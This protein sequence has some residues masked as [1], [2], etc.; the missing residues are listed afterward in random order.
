MGNIRFSTWLA[1]CAAVVLSIYC[2]PGA[3]MASSKQ[4]GTATIVGWN[5]THEFIRRFFVGDAWGSNVYP[6]LPSGSVCCV[7]YPLKWTADFKVKVRWATASADP[8]AVGKDAEP[9]WHEQEVQVEKYDR[10]GTL[11][12]HFLADRK[13][14]VIIAPVDPGHP[15]YPGPGRPTRPAA[16]PVQKP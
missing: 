16:A 11:H 3:A 14:R 8:N 15:D 5:H 1:A 12:V 7:Q 6:Y 9:V 13:I 2:A 4:G 10:P